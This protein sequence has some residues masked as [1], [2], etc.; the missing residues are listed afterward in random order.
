MRKILFIYVLMLSA[1]FLTACSD[2]DD[3]TPRLSFGR[4]IYILRD[5]TPLAVELVASV[6]PTEAISVPIDISG[7]A[8]LD[9]DYTI[10]KD[11][12]TLQPGQ[13]ID[14]I[15]I[16]PKDNVTSQ[17]EIR[18]ALREVAGYQ[19]WN[20]RV[21]MIPVETKD[22]FSCSFEETK[23]D[24]KNEVIVK[25]GLLLN[26]QM[27]YTSTNEVRVPFDIDPASTAVLGEHYEIVGEAQELVMVG[28]YK[29]TAD[30]TLRFLKHEE[31]KDKVIFRLHEGGLFER[32]NFSATTI[33][34]SGPTT[35]KA[36]VGKWAYNGEFPSESFIRRMAGYVDPNDCDN[37]PLDNRLTDI[38]EFVA[39]ADNTLNIDQ[40]Q[41]DL[42]KYLRNCKAEFGEE[43]PWRL[44]EE[45]GM[46]TRDVI[47]LYLEKANVNYSATNISERRVFVGIRLLDKSQ[48]LELRIVDYEPTDFLTRSYYDQMHP[49]WGEPDE[50]PMK[51]LYPLVFRFKK[52]E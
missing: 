17:R 31:G 38:I 27:Y 16:T 40:V 7:T 19:L 12:F 51:D 3:S 33:T 46:P 32:G 49:G 15:W 2:D 13:T 50:F 11:A 48:M 28:R 1:C 52:V 6:A 18:L 25:M 24:L 26:G 21:A 4:P 43:G 42:T 41:G 36:L 47:T 8:I 20:N 9:E 30:V 22:V 23:Y 34:V 14:T 29:S 35:F 5:V 39:G 37:L 10:E 45:T 44:Y